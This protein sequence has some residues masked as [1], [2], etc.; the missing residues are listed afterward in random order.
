M[1][2]TF[3]LLLLSFSVHGQNIVMISFYTSSTDPN[4]MQDGSSV[5]IEIVNTNFDSCIMLDLTHF[6]VESIVSLQVKDRR[7]SLITSTLGHLNNFR[8]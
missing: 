6:S 8:C 4:G 7:R 5:D 1:E 3:M 2:V